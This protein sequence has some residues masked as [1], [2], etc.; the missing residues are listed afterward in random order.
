MKITSLP[1]AELEVMQV[2]WK[3]ETPIS[4]SQINEILNQT[5]SWNVSALQTILN[6][7]ITKG[8]LSSEKT[9][10]NRFYDIIINEATYLSYENKK[11]LKKVNSSVVKFVAS[12]YDSKGLT[13][14]DLEELHA[15][16]NQKTKGE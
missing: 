5:R 14:K 4:T 11:Y 9:G 10:K 7:L 13:K 15:F 2:I 6:R 1:D 3:N 16:I 8:Y 12:L